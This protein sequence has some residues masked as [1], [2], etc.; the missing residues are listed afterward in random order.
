M[1]NHL[2]TDHYNKYGESDNI[3]I[4]PQNLALHSVIMRYDNP[5]IYLVVA[6]IIS[7]SLPG[8][9]TGGLVERYVL[10]LPLIY[11]WQHFLFAEI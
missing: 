9:S 3:L 4:S 5:L 7:V 10:Y 8:G 1:L 6:L 2:S 11:F